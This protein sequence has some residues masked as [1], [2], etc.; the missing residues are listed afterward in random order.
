MTPTQAKAKYG[1]D[2]LRSVLEARFPKVRKAAMGS[3]TCWASGRMDIYVYL[4]DG[5]GQDAKII[6]KCTRGTIEAFVAAG[7][8]QRQ[9]AMFAGSDTAQE[10]WW[11]IEDPE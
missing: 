11:R 6:G 2:M 7:L 10:T 9:S 5:K 4:Y 3:C 8:F 1:R